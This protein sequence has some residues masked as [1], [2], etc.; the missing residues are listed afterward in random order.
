MLYT[1]TFWY[2]C[3]ANAVE[4]HVLQMNTLLRRLCMTRRKRLNV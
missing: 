3:Q 1:R 4:S 2:T